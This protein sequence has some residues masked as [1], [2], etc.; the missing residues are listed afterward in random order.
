MATQQRE[1]D[2]SAQHQINTAD[3]ALFEGLTLADRVRSLIMQAC[4]TDEAPGPADLTNDGLMKPESQDFE[5][6]AFKQLKDA[7]VFLLEQ[8]NLHVTN[9]VFDEWSKQNKDALKVAAAELRLQTEY[10][11]VLL[12][13]HT[14]QGSEQDS[15]NGDAGSHTQMTEDGRCAWC[16][17]EAERQLL[18]GSHAGKVEEKALKEEPED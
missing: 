6:A 7:A 10:M 1:E 2:M 4:Q 17:E 16:A 15:R 8:L 3:A 5:L 9:T 18:S 12:T 11:H 13:L 14:A